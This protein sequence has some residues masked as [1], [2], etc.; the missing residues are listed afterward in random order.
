MGSYG[1]GKAAWSRAINNHLV[2][3]SIHTQ[4][5]ISAETLEGPDANIRR[6]EPELPPLFTHPFFSMFFFTAVFS[7]YFFNFGKPLQIFF[8]YEFGTLGYFLPATVITTS[9]N[10]PS[11]MDI[12]DRGFATGCMC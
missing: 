10:G 12:C 5:N 11:L 6:Q 9:T 4:L 1:T 7:L 8:D 3:N 2:A